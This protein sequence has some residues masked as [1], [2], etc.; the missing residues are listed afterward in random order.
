MTPNDIQVGK[1][2][3]RRDYPCSRWI[4][5]G[6]RKPYTYGKDAEFTEKHMVCIQMEEDC[7]GIGLI[8]KTPD[9]E[10]GAWESDWELFYL[11]PCQNPYTP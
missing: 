7:N 6:K 4:G 9:D 3:L 2:Y 5:C 1:F 8:F 10:D 11:D